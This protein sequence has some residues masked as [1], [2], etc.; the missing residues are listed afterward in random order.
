MPLL[1]DI[2]SA[3]CGT[4]AGLLGSPHPAAAQQQRTS[5]LLSNFNFHCTE[6]RSPLV[7][8]ANSD[9]KLAV[10]PKTHTRRTPHSRS[11][12]AHG[13][14]SCK[15]NS[16]HPLSG[17][18]NSRRPLRAGLICS[19]F[20]RRSCVYRKEKAAVFKV[21]G[22]SEM[23]K[24]NSTDRQSGI[25]PG[26]FCCARKLPLPS[27]HRLLVGALPARRRACVWPGDLRRARS[28]V[29]QRFPRIVVHKAVGKPQGV[30]LLRGGRGRRGGR[31]MTAGFAN[32]L[33][34][35]LGS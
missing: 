3:W 25:T 14:K 20:L 34:S 21:G 1:C 15:V 11:Q 24:S 2:G 4:P 8:E 5:F 23:T 13:H 33:R 10:S 16:P 31:G 26:Y 18:H 29:R 27:I 30:G 17:V 6:N 35:T 7:V 28:Q 32:K 22:R 9:P 12:L 19:G